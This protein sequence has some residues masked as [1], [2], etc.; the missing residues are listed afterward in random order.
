MTHHEPG[1]I[2]V[3]VD[4]GGRKK[5]FHAVALEDGHYRE[6]LSTLIATE[7]AEWCRR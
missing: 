2:V 7:I 5:G 4:V 1:S 3:G 6:K